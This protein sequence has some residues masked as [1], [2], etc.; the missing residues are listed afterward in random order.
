MRLPNRID[1]FHVLSFHALTLELF[2][3][4]DSLPREGASD[5]RS[6][7]LNDFDTLVQGRSSDRVESFVR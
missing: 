4:L 1:F 7:E 5:Q 3:A 2:T 6:V